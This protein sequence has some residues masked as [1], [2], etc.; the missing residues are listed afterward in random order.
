MEDLIATFVGGVVTGAG[1]LYG[2]WKSIPISK[3]KAA[4]SEIREGMEDGKLTISEGM[5]ALEELF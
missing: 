3:K 5:A 4:F 2:Y 1:I